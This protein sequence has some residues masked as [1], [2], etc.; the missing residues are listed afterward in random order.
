MANEHHLIFMFAVWSFFLR[1][2]LKYNAYFLKIVLFIYLLIFHINHLLSISN[3]A[4]D[5]NLKSKF[6]F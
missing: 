6:L 4:G 1:W 3:S 5:I 2:L